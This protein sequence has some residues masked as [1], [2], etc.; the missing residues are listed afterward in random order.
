LETDAP[1]LAPVPMRGK[2]NEPAFVTHVTAAVARRLDVMPDELARRT[3]E[4]ACRFYG[5]S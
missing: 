2:R 3:T 1:Y 5:V 4:N